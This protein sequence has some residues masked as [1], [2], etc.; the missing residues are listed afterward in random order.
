MA[1]ASAVTLDALSSSLRVDVFFFQRRLHLLC[2]YPL[3]RLCKFR[4]K[5]QLFSLS[6]EK[7]SL[8]ISGD[9]DVF[10]LKKT[11]VNFWRFVTLQRN[12]VLHILK[13]IW[14]SFKIV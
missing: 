6:F 7:Y 3:S 12:I 14:V 2:N 8:K 4:K 10:K 11:N 9:F 13:N 5:S 1:L